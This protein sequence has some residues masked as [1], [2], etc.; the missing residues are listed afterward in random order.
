M[1]YPQQAN[2]FFRLTALTIIIL[3][4]CESESA[5]LATSSKQALQLQSLLLRSCHMHLRIDG[6]TTSA[7]QSLP[8]T[9]GAP[10]PAL[11]LTVY[12]MNQHLHEPSAVN[13]FF[14]QFRPQM[15]CYL[16]LKQPGEHECFSTFV[17][18]FNARFVALTDQL[19]PVAYLGF[20]K[21]G[22]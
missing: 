19:T 1:N 14:H 11:T 2:K 12:N 5:A 22:G 17:I 18:I 16:L 6:Y 4:T 10:P 20:G 7:A 15:P 13:L 3:L 8:E 9:G 21:G